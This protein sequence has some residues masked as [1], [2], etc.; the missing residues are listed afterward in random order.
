[1]MPQLHTPRIETQRRRAQGGAVPMSP[2]SMSAT[3]Q[4]GQ[5]RVYQIFTQFAE[6]H[7]RRRGER[8][9]A[10]PSCRANCKCSWQRT[11][12][13][14]RTKQI[15]NKQQTTNE[16]RSNAELSSFIRSHLIN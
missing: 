10:A 7:R 15:T 8:F 5:T 12:C 2:A 9:L 16:Q 14:A 13:A 4:I 6:D 3:L 11:I 1:M